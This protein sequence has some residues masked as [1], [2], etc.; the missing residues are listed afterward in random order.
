LWFNG[1]YKEDIRPIDETR[2]ALEQFA[3]I[4][5]EPTGVERF[6]SKYG[7]LRWGWTREGQREGVLARDDIKDFTFSLEQFA[8]SQREFVDQWALASSI[9]TD[10]LR[11]VAEWLAGNLGPQ[12]MTS[13]V[14]N[15]MDVWKLA[16][17]KLGM[18]IAVGRHLNSGVEV[19][20]ALGDLWQGLCWMLLEKLTERSGIVRVCE[21]ESCEGRKYFIAIRAAQK[22]CDAHCAKL[23]ADRNSARRRRAKDRRLKL[24]GV[25]ENAKTKKA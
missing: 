12:P 3:N 1:D 8:E 5:V 6:I 23:V 11:R 4:S 18:K 2:S 17:P 19:E 24:K 20:L 25:L 16:Q 7:L 14:D 13:S 15:W 22:H 10:K 9:R 21:N